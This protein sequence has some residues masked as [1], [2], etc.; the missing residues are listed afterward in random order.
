MTI[1]IH[2]RA[3][4][5][6]NFI[7]LLSLRALNETI[8]MSM[9]TCFRFKGSHSQTGKLLFSHFDFVH[10]SQTRRNVAAGGFVCRSLM[11][12]QQKYRSISTVL[13]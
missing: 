2:I 9:K 6:G 3:R 13:L 12:R 11:D 4:R 5:D 7:R 8:N 10:I 1:C